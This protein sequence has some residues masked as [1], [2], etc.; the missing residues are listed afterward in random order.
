MKHSACCSKGIRYPNPEEVNTGSAFMGVCDGLP[1]DSEKESTV[2]IYCLAAQRN[3]TWIMTQE[4]LDERDSSGSFYWNGMVQEG[5][6]EK[7]VN[8]QTFCPT[9]VFFGKLMANGLIKTREMIHLEPTLEV[10][11]VRVYKKGFVKMVVILALDETDAISLA[12]NEYQQNGWTDFS[13]SESPTGPFKR[14][15]VLFSNTHEVDF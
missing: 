5:W 9:D 8:T 1:N 7:G 10:F 11:V 14:G 4:Q 3:N 12:E 15:S 2:R 6:F 13:I